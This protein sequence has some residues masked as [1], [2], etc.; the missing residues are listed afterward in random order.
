M[1]PAKGKYI[2]NE[3][4]DSEYMRVDVF[5]S[6]IR[7]YISKGYKVFN[8]YH[9]RGKDILMVQLKDGKG[10]SVT[11]KEHCTYPVYKF[12]TRH[13]SMEENIFESLY[14]MSN[15]KC[16]KIFVKANVL[17]SVGHISYDERKP[18]YYETIHPEK[19]LVYNVLRPEYYVTTNLRKAENLSF[20]ETRICSLDIEIDAKDREFPEPS[21]AERPIALTTVFDFNNK[22]ANVFYLDGYDIEESQE[23]VKKKIYENMPNSSIGI[24]E[25]SIS[26]NKFTDEASLVNGML[27]FIGDNFDILVGWNVNEFDIAYIVNRCKKYLDI[28][29]QTYVVY[30]GF[31]YSY[32]FPNFVCL[33]YISI[34]KFFVKKNPPSLKL[35]DIAKSVINLNKLPT[36][37]FIDSAYNIADAMLVCLIDKELSLINQMFS[38]KENGALLHVFNVRN[39]LE[40][41]II[42][43]GMKYNKSFIANQY[44]TYY[45][46]YFNEVYK[47]INRDLFKLT[48]REDFPLYSIKNIVNFLTQLSSFKDLIESYTNVSDKKQD[49]EDK[50]DSAGAIISKLVARIFK[51]LKRPKKVEPDPVDFEKLPTK[52]NFDYDTETFNDIIL[53]LYGINKD[54]IYGYP[55]A[56]NKSFRGIADGIIDLDFFSMYPVIM[57]GLN[58]SIETAR[59]LV[60]LKLNALRVFD[61]QMYEEYVTG[62]KGGRICV[63]NCLTDVIEMLSLEELEKRCYHDNNIIA[64]SGM[65]FDKTI[66]MIPR[67]CAYFLDVRAKYKKLMQTETD[68]VVKSKYNILQLLYKVYNNSIYGYLGYK[69]SVIFNRLL[70]SSVTTMGRSE[71]LYANYMINSYF[72]DKGGA[73]DAQ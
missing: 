49:A 53:K 13:I 33:D 1:K 69:Y 62:C 72:K 30:D 14:Y 70:V 27:S 37:S 60:P 50:E 41:L 73:I 48:K 20:E 47:F 18:P 44:T 42:K 15:D 25:L 35:A 36:D 45:N 38:F 2:P 39:A 40:P 71:I 56:F 65:I 59:F 63:Y 12:V 26:F 61:K 4:A 23:V 22:I 46:I 24:D 67:M 66:G 9:F 32:V 52:K 17:D 68:P 51:V 55:G 3:V 8:S 29:L 28:K 64:T 31:T 34:Y 19:N 10:G 5:I 58:I 54:T 43:Y 7:D 11:I 16:S 57:Y 21:K 6:K